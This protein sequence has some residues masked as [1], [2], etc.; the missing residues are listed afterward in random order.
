MEYYDRFFDPAQ[1]ELQREHDA[2]W[3]GSDGEGS[4]R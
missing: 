3:H 2:L 1:Y 4:G